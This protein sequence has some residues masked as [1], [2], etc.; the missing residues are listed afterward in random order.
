MMTEYGA[1][2]ECVIYLPRSPLIDTLQMRSA[3][4]LL[5]SASLE[6][7]QLASR[8]LDCEVLRPLAA[9]VISYALVQGDENIIR[10]LSTVE[11]FDFQ[12]HAQ[13]AFT[14]DLEV[15]S[16]GT[17]WW[18]RYPVSTF[19][20]LIDPSLGLVLNYPLAMEG[21]IRRGELEIVQFLCTCP[22][23]DLPA[24]SCSYLIDAVYDYVTQGDILEYLLSLP[25]VVVDQDIVDD[26]LDHGDGL[27]EKILLEHPKAREYALVHDGRPREY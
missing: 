21:A 25:E 19:R 14:G 23:V 4:V 18:D 6:G 10:Y 20:L 7:I 15:R 5:L 24:N 1:V 22:E 12:Q 9:E 17:I 2:P 27:A 26:L 8:L 13:K 3:K 11:C 16:G